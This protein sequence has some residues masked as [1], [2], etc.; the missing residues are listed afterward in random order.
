VRGSA[1]YG[2]D[3]DLEGGPPHGGGNLDRRIEECC[4]PAFDL[5]FCSCRKRIGTSD[6][7]ISCRKIG[8]TARRCQ[9]QSEPSVRNKDVFPITGVKARCV[10]SSRLN[11]AALSTSIS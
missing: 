9:R 7:S 6:N 8:A 2:F 11:A 4:A 1:Q 10:T 3:N 5:L